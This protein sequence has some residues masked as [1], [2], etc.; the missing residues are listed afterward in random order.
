[1][2]GRESGSQ[3]NGDDAA[4]FG[5]K[6]PQPEFLQFTLNLRPLPCE[7]CCLPELRQLHSQIAGPYSRDG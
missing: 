2:R 7:G 6:A 1:L 4:R 5:H 3:Q